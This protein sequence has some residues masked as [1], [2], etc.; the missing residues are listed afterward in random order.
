MKQ[1]TA[2]KLKKLQKKYPY[3]FSHLEL[4]SGEICLGE[5]PPE[6]ALTQAAIFR[7][8]GINSVRVGSTKTYHPI[9]MQVGS[10]IDNKI[11]EIKRNVL[12]FPIFAKIEEIESFL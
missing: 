8:S 1:E 2:E 6:M 5:W 12:H 4:K 9:T 3:M 10:W 7:K 11:E